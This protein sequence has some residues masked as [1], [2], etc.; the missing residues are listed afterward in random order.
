MTHHSHSTQ[1]LLSGLCLAGGLAIAVPAGAAEPPAQPDYHYTFLEAAKESMFGDV[2]S[3]PSKWQELSYS[4]FFSEGWNKPWASPPRGNGGAPRMG[5][6]N[7]F[8]GVFYRLSIAVFGW[9]HDKAGVGGDGYTGTIT[10]FTP[11]NQRF[12]VQTD[13]P[14]AA[15]NRA[16]PGLDSETNFGDFVITP[17]FLLSETRDVTQIFQLG[18]R[19]PTG[20]SVNGNGWA[21]FVPSYNFWANLWQGLVVRGGVNFSVPYAGEINRAGARSTFGANLA[22]GYYF[23]PHD[24]T[25][26]GDLVWFLSTN[27]SQPID[28]RQPT[29]T[30]MVSLSPGFRSHLG[31]DWYLHGAV[32]IPVTNPGKP[33]DYQVLGGIMKVY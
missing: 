9:Q 13:I 12:Q 16:G 31:S 33:F 7:S 21:A 25:P 1:R 29:N 20:N 3:E 15:S 4:N 11:L 5:W 24:F 28:Q 8:E 27:L 32:E 30:T 2:Y 18:F 17:R 22:V 10:T 23:T 6:L 26:F 14:V 19:T